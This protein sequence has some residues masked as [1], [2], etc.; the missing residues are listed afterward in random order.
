MN[1]NCTQAISFK[2]KAFVKPRKVKLFV[3][4]IIL[5]LISIV[6]YSQTLR[7]T[8]T[9]SD[10]KGEPLP[11]VGIKVKGNNIGVSTSVEGKYVIDVPDAKA[12]LVFTYIGF[13]TEEKTVG[14][15]KVL[16]VK[17]TENENALN[18]V[19]IT[20]YGQAVKRRDLT[21][22]ISSVSAKQ[23]EERQPVTLYDALQGQAA[24]V[25]VTNDSGD[26]AGQGTIQI[27]NASTIGGSTGP[28]YVIDGALSEN[29]NFVNPQD[30]ASIEVLKDASSAAIYGARGANGVIL[31]TTKRGKEGRPL[32]TANYTH[33]IGELAHQLRTTSADELRLY[34]SI[35]GAGNGGASTDSVNPYLNADND[36]QELLFKT[37]HK[38]VASLSLS[39]GTKGASY[40][41]GFTYTDDKAIILNSWM[42]RIQTS[43]NADF[44]ISPKL[45][46][47][48]SLAFAYQNGNNVPIGTSAK[49]IF[50]R[51]PWTSIYRPDGTLASYVESKRNPIAFALLAEDVDNNYTTKFNTT[52]NY[53]FNK[54][55]K[56]TTVFNSQLDNESNNQFETSQL[57]SGGNGNAVGSNEFGKEMRWE[58][59]ALLNYNKTFGKSHN[60]SALLGVG[61]DKRKENSYLISMDGYLT[62]E[63]NTSNAGTIDLTE[64]STNANA[65]SS[66]NLFGRVNYSYL[67]R[68]ILQGSFRRDGSSR[69]G[70]NNR[71]G[72]FLSASAA[73]RFSDEKFMD[74]SKGFLEDAKL[75]FSVGSVGNDNIG[76]YPSRTSIEFNNYYA[77]QGAAYQSTSLGNPNI[78]WETTTTADYGLELT[79]FKGKMTFNSS[80]YTK[81]TKD[82]LYAKEI[83]KETGARTTTINLGTIANRGLE[84][85]LY[86]N[87]ITKRNFSWNAR[88]NISFQ[89]GKIK[90]LAN[91]TSQIVGNIFFLQEGGK[92]GDM[93]VWK[94][95]GVYQYDVSNAYDAQG[96]KLTPEGITVNEATNTSTAAGYSLN[97]QTYSGTVYQKTRNGI[98][99]QGG[100]TEWFDSNNDN[101]IDDNDLIIG[102]NALPDFYFG[103]TNDFRYKAFTL[104]FTF[105]GQFGNSVYNSVK[106]GQNTNSSTYSP[107]SW[108]AAIGSWQQQGDIS[109]YPLFTRKDTRGSI[110][111]GYNS[112]YIEDGSFIRL[113]SMRLAYQLKPEL[114]QKIK[115]KHAQLYIFGTNLAMWTDYSW[116]DPEF[117]S[118]NP[119]VKGVD[120]GKYPK[121]RELGLGLNLNF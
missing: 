108:D 14:G 42:K 86:G 95:L 109:Q 61:A 36:Y 65:N 101:V 17:L 34:R 56:F 15:N 91:H 120:N 74:W 58:T 102:G 104:N 82:L 2:M 38:Q 53:D 78:K 10:S 87:P 28:L 110:K 77:G 105:N 27:R 62:E 59:Q 51:N 111:N 41:A 67:S 73:W 40:Y 24:G 12:V 81:T 79:L 3:L 45:K 4:M 21:G 93:L 70:A 75:R 66:A 31:I 99:L 116:Y 16:N 23:I 115:M 9:V 46:I 63:I 52:L 97:G 55:L 113:A 114:A 26:P 112:L 121:R 22:S 39:G 48:N 84:F 69:F 49:Q 119:L 92:I 37:A 89:N 72:N 107:P 6:V 98:V 35:R 60:V 18:E 47:A 44:Q 103:F 117:S 76:N 54:N 64:T 1:K 19:V 71:W 118:S 13:A 80:Y 88:G 106:N 57:T 33:T 90:E 25:L 30:I 20:G 68:Y 83:P 32:I 11:G 85:E 50:E 5:Q 100:D 8:G 94:N 7:V 29:A 96:N 43:I